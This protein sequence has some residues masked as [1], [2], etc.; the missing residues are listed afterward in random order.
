[1]KEMQEKEFDR[2]TFKPN[3]EECV[4]GKHEVVKLYMFGT[5]TDYGCIKCGI[6]SL[7]LEY[8]GT[9]KKSV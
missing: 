7:C 1:M 4:L 5:H 6:K 2:I 8:F 9:R 3:N